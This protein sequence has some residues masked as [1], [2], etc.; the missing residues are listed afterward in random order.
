M[1][2]LES[3]DYENAVRLAVSLVG[4]NWG[5]GTIDQLVLW[6]VASGRGSSATTKIDAK[7]GTERLYPARASVTLPAAPIARINQHRQSMWPV[8]GS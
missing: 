4:D 8:K 6:D 5:E 2:L 3:T 7:S 1:A